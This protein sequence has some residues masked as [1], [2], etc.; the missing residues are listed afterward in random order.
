MGRRK[1][2]DQWKSE[3]TEKHGEKYGYDKVVLADKDPGKSKVDIWCNECSEFFLQAPAVH[4]KGCGCPKCGNKKIGDTLRGEKKSWIKKAIA[5]HGEGA[6]GYQDVEYINALT[7]VTIW[8]NKHNKSFSQTPSKHL[9]GT[10]CKEC[11]YERV[12]KANRK[13]LDTLLSECE[14]RWWARFDY[15]NVP[16]LFVDYQSKV[17]IIC[18][19]HNEEFWQTPSGHLQCQGCGSCESEA[20]SLANSDSHEDLPLFELVGSNNDRW[21]LITDRLHLYTGISHYAW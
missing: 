21:Q 1:T 5:K 6:F 8:C 18:L 14:E 20:I 11:R 7:H 19:K 13:S 3:W 15:S 12:S 4:A 17:K 10:G 9:S 16:S 2:L